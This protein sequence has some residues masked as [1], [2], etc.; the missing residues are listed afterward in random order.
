V[1]SP[2]FD[3]FD[4]LEFPRPP[5]FVAHRVEKRHRTVDEPEH[6]EVGGRSASLVRAHQPKKGIVGE[7]EYFGQPFEGA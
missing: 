6:R 5:A 1:R 3:D 7:P 2:A 4:R